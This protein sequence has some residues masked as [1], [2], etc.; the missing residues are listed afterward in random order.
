MNIIDQIIELKKEYKNT[1]G[2]TYAQLYRNYKNVWLD[3]R[4]EVLMEGS[5]VTGFMEWTRQPSLNFPL[6]KPDYGVFKGPYLYI[7]NV[8]VVKGNLWD[9]IK[10]VRK[11]NKFVEYVCWDNKRGRHIYSM[12]RKEFDHGRNRQ[13]SPQMAYAT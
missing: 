4:L 10:R 3:G 7:V 12:N 8:V 9:M 2:E 5:Q 13:D 6:Y 1:F 11:K